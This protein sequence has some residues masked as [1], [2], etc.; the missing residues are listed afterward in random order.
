MKIRFDEEYIKRYNKISKTLKCSKCRI[1]PYISYDE[2]N[3][4][5]TTHFIN[6]D[7]TI[8]FEEETCYGFKV[9]ENDEAIF[10]L[11]AELYEDEILE[12]ETTPDKVS[13]KFG[14]GATYSKRREVNHYFTCQ[15]LKE[16]KMTITNIVFNP[17]LLEAVCKLFKEKF[18]IENNITRLYLYS[19]FEDFKQRAVILGCKGV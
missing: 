9:L 3:K 13:Y 4:S 15:E 1:S 8:L 2:E 10:N 19:G 18:H 5:I 12:I 6:E 16:N 17:K 7:A 11:E 14:K